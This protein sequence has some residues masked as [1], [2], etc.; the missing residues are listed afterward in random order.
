MSEPSGLG[1][2]AADH[3]PKSTGRRATARTAD[4][5]S[6]QAQRRAHDDERG[7]AVRVQPREPQREQ[8]AHRE[9][10]DRDG[11]ARDARLQRVE[12]ALG[13][14]EPVAPRRARERGERRVTGE[15]RRLD[16][17]PGST[18]GL[19]ERP[20]LEGRARDAVQTQ[21]APLVA[22]ERERGLVEGGS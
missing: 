1:M 15:Q 17:E 8:R 9:A 11:A 10:A 14:R 21:N 19:G 22:R 7:D 12:R 4:L 2:L 5:E 13:R 20:D 6:T 3:R 16:G 18:K